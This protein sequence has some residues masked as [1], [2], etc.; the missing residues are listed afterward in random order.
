MAL[1]YLHTCLV[2]F[3]WCSCKKNIPVPWIPW[4][5]IEFLWP[6]GLVPFQTM[7][8]FQ[9]LVGHEIALVVQH[10]PFLVHKKEIETMRTIP[11]KKIQ[12]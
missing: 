8:F 10:L 1:V 4:L 9:G 12:K 7:L 6:T 5:S 3:L 11:E 2:D